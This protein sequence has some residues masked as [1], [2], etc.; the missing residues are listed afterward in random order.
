MRIRILIQVIS[1]RLTEFFS[2][3]LFYGPALRNLMIRINVEFYK[4]FRSDYS[5]RRKPTWLYLAGNFLAPGWKE[6]FL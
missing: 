5:D 3:I 1:L 4:Q 6:G 2:L